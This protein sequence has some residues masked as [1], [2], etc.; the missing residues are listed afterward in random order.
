MFNLF[1]GLIVAYLIG[2]IPTAYLFAKFIK[3]ID[4]RNFGSGNVG[5]TN[6]YREVGKLPGFIVLAVDILKGVVPILFIPMVLGVEG[7]SIGLDIH[8]I[9]IGAM[10]IT[11]H[12]W[13]VFLKFKGGK[14][15]ATTTGVA[16]VLAPKV[17]GIAFL[18]W[19]I[20]FLPFRYVSLASIAAAITLPIAALILGE[21]KSIVLFF[22]IIGAV[23][24]YKHKSNISRLLKGEERRI[25]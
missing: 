6:I 13:T 8:K 10:T 3:G 15:V 20:F 21:P 19:V 1:L 11:G 12:V 22:A 17:L 16:L 4:I 5:A 23:G 7:T 18:A 25:A 2:S 14:G 9:L 24:I